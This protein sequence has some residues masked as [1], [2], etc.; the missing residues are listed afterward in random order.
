MWPSV[1]ATLSKAAGEKFQGAVQGYASSFGGVASIVGL[2]LGGIIYELLGAGIFI[3]S[4]GIIYTVFFMAL[5]LF[6]I[7]KGVP[8]IEGP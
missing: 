2:T 4:A 1:L 3:L 6:Y 8:A 7:R 5:G